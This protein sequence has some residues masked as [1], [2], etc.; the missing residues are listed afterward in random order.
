MKLTIIKVTLSN[1][2]SSKTNQSFSMAR[3]LALIPVEITSSP[4]YQVRGAGYSTYEYDVSDS[5]ID[6]FVTRFKTDFKGSPVVYDL[7]TQPRERGNNIILGFSEQQRQ[8][9]SAVPPSPQPA[10]V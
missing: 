3:A 2:I 6:D 4:N 5:F 9:P 10:K 8:Q 1:G 7:D